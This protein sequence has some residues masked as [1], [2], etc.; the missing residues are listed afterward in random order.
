MTQVL[1]RQVAFIF[2]LFGHPKTCINQALLYFNMDL[3][4]HGPLTCN[5]HAVT[6]VLHNHE[7]VCTVLIYGHSG[8]LLHSFLL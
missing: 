3:L 4:I 7:R 2:E 8:N 5:H 1:S 6:V